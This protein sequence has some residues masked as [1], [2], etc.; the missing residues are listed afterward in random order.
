MKRAVPT[1]RFSIRKPRFPQAGLSPF[2]TPATASAALRARRSAAGCASVV[3]A[4]A[5]LLLRNLHGALNG[6][7]A[8]MWRDC[9]K[10]SAEKFDPPLVRAP[11]LSL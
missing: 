3:G 4:G 6:V 7:T 1:R 11:S 9:L 10:G 8:Q 2:W 5:S